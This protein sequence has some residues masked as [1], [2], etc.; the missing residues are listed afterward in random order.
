M[1]PSQA[2]AEAA[3][4]RLEPVAFYKLVKRIVFD[5]LQALCGAPLGFGATCLANCTGKDREQ[6]PHA[7]SLPGQ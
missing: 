5:V 1:Q 7:T 6:S 2:D 4:A 3:A